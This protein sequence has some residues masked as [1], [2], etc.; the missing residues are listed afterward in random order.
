MEHEGALYH[1]PPPSPWHSASLRL[2][3]HR[4]L[5][6]TQG[7]VEWPGKAADARYYISG[8]RTLEEEC[9]MKQRVVSKKDQRN[10]LTVANPGEG[11]SCTAV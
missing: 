8:E 3:Q 5:V 9:G 10:G 1:A 2:I 6:C 7:R 11:R 4:G